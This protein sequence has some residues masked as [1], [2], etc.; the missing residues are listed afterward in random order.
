MQSDANAS[1]QHIQ[2]LN[3]QQQKPPVAQDNLQKITAFMAKHQIAGLPRNF[4]LVYEAMVSRNAEVARDLLA[5]GAQPS[6]IALDHLG[7]IGRAHV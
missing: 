3:A 2:P 7:Q 4:E 6:Q 1:H 5:L